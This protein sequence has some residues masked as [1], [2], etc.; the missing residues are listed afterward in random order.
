MTNPRRTIALALGLTLSA[1]AAHA[2][3]GTDAIA[4]GKYL[5][6]IMTCNECHT[7]G[8]LLGKPREPILSG[9]EVGYEMPGMGVY[10]GANLTGDNETGLGMWSEDDIVKAIRTGERPDGRI[11]APVMPLKAFSHLSDEDAYAIAKY[12][13]SLPAAKNVPPGPFG[14]SETPSS[15]YYKFTMPPKPAAP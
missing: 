7:P 8:V 3:E 11:I 9:S 15:F 4:R 5:T 6:E 12:L 2:V 1:I 14:P 13:K 10:Y